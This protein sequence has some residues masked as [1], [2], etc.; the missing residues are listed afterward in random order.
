MLKTNSFLSINERK[1]GPKIAKNQPLRVS[2]PEI[3]TRQAPPVARS[4]GLG[5]TRVSPQRVTGRRL[6]AR[7]RSQNLRLENRPGNVL[8]NLGV[9]LTPTSTE[10]KPLGRQRV[11][12]KCRRLYAAIWRGKLAATPSNTTSRPEIVDTFRQ[13]VLRSNNCVSHYFLNRNR[14]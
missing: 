2:E 14:Y 1:L 7:H 11:S 6:L 8:P 3:A 12:L 9:T 10:P 4:A 5:K 13:L